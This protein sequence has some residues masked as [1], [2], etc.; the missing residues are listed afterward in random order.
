[1]R[2]SLYSYVSSKFKPGEPFFYEDLFA[3]SQNKDS[4][5]HQISNLKKSGKIEA[6][7]NGMFFIPKKSLLGLPSV[8]S[9]DSVVVSKY[10][11]HGDEI[12]G[13][14][15]GQ[16]FANQ[17]GVSLQVPMMK[18]I[19]TNKSSAKVRVVN[20]NKRDFQIRKPKV[21]VNNSNYKILQLLSLLE[22]YDKLVDYE[23]VDADE[24]I[25]NYAKINNISRNDLFNYADSFPKSLKTIKA[26]G[27]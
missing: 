17:I 26:L 2:K 24:R 25:R 16:T 12:I 5:R 22:S 23:V 3:F 7:S 13:Y 15:S 1:M 6:H 18:E 10:I 4:L 21:Q 9:T 11:K 20:I 27:L 19:I 14:Y 8:I